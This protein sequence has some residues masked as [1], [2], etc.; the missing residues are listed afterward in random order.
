MG[1][2][3]AA[4]PALSGRTLLEVL[5]DFG[6]ATP[7]LESLLM[8]APRLKPRLFSISSSLALHPR[9]AHVTVAIVD[10]ITPYKRRKRGVCSSWL[11]RLEPGARVP[12]WV[13]RGA[14][15]LPADPQVPLVMVGPG[16]GV[17][18]FRAFLQQRQ[19]QLESGEH[20]GVRTVCC[21]HP[22]RRPHVTGV[23]THTHTRLRRPA[24]ATLAVSP[25]LWLPQ[26]AR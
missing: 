16:T 24:P 21:V 9:A 13:Q 22:G 19:A 1:I 25:L 18:P 23:H 15:R 12:V 2:N 14:L 3:Q 4:P 17:A 6:S 20:E 7:Q 5:N 26:R 10:W 8:A 11:A